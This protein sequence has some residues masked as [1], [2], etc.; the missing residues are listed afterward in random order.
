M[1]ADPEDFNPKRIYDDLVKRCKKARVWYI[2]CI[3]DE[4]WVGI[5]PFEMWIVDGIF[6]C[7][8]VATTR[9]DAFLQVTNK[10]PVVKFLDDIN[11]N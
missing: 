5:A 8:V 10:L 4:A 2:R 3:L 11:G 1:I 9:R 7:R 6:T